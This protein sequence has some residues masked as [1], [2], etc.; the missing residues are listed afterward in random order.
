[1]YVRDYDNSGN[2]F[3][4]LQSWINNETVNR[5]W[6]AGMFSWPVQREAV[7]DFLKEDANRHPYVAIDDEGKEFGFFILQSSESSNSELVRLVVV[8]STERGKGYGSALLQLAADKAFRE[9]GRDY[10]DLDVFREN[11]RAIR[12]YKKNGFA[13]MEEVNADIV[14]NGK[15]WPRYHMRK[16]NG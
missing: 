11:E 9:C 4:L 10:I 5:Q 13:I 16:R 7:E 3:L 6:C 8:D 2:D 14:I 15:L 1:M 12:C